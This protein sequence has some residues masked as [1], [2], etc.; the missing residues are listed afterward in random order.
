MIPPD[1]LSPATV[2]EAAGDLPTLLPSTLAVR[3]EIAGMPD[4]YAVV[5]QL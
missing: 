1:G 3:E 4:A 2:A 5:S